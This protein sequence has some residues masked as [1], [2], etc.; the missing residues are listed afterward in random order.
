M[1][2][3]AFYTF[4]VKEIPEVTSMMTDDDGKIIRLPKYVAV[5]Y[6]SN[7]CI[8]AAK[9][10]ML[11]LMVNALNQS[12]SHAVVTKFSVSPKNII[13]YGTR[14]LA[15]L[16]MVSPAQMG[17]L[18]GQVSVFRP[19][20]DVEIKTVICRAK[21]THVG[22]KMLLSVVYPTMERMLEFIAF[23]DNGSLEIIAKESSETLA[24]DI[25]NN[26]A[27]ESVEN[28]ETNFISN[29]MLSSPGLVAWLGIVAMYMKSN[30]YRLNSE[31]PKESI[32]HL[33]PEYKSLVVDIQVLDKFRKVTSH[34]SNF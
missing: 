23:T 6:Q 34:G 1:L 14:E 20:L 10:I 13:M 4:E 31:E 17:S 12:A 15:Y 22:T 7:M 8:T 18:T 30:W 9:T 25:A 21:N 29:A 32:L 11:S 5:P 24:T 27:H 33:V 2:R 3:F 16:T 19:S 26:T 28:I